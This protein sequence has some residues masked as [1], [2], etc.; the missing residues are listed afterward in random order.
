MKLTVLIQGLLA[1]TSAAAFAGYSVDVRLDK[2]DGFYKVGEE[3]SCTATLMKD[4]R[5]AAGERLRCTVKRERDIVRQDEFLC[6]GKAVTIR[7]SMDRP[8]WLFFGFEIIGPDGNP[9][10]GEGIGKHRTAP[11]TT[12]PQR[13]RPATSVFRTSSAR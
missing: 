6:D 2:S 7:A 12:E 8:G 4:G 9:L 1:I 3:T 10:Q 13:T 5:P 11:G